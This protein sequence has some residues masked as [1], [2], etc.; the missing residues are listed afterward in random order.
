MKKLKNKKKSLSKYYFNQDC[1]L[2]SSEKTD[3][4]IVGSFWQGYHLLFKDNINLW[5]SKI[6]YWLYKPKLFH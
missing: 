3:Y 1:K 6:P 4:R 5:L 2:K